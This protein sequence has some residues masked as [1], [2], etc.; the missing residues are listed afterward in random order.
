MD[1]RRMRQVGQVSG[2]AL[3]VVLMSSPV[4]HSQPAVIVSRGSNSS[5]QC[6]DP[7]C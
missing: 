1:V 3:A 5:R 6:H 2:A 7:S 4:P